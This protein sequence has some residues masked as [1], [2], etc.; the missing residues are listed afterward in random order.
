M[1]DST[2]ALG[3]ALIARGYAIF[4]VR[5]AS[6]AEPGTREYDEAK[7]P[8]AGMLWRTASSRDPGQVARWAQAFPGHRWAIDCGKSGV[9]VADLDEGE[10]HGRQREGRASW[11]A[12]GLDTADAAEVRT[13]GGGSHLFYAEPSGAVVGVNNTGA[14]GRDIDIRGLG[15]YVLAY[16]LP[17]AVD[18]LPALPGVVIERI[19]AGRSQDQSRE[20]AGET[21]AGLD[22]TGDPFSGPSRGFS[23]EEAGRYVGEALDR[24]RAAQPGGRNHA[25][26]A[27]AMQVGHFVP[28]F[29]PEATVVERLTAIAE[30]IGL[31]A[32]EARATIASGLA[33]GMRE[34]YEPRGKSDAP[35]VEG[36]DGA[37]GLDA[38]D[39]LLAEMLDTEGLDEIGDLRPLVKGWLSRNTVA[40]INGKS[41][42]GKSFIALDLAAH[43]GAGIDWRGAKVTQGTVVY[44]IAEGA[45]GF[46]KRVRA[47]E[48]WHGVRMRHVRFLPRPIQ[49]TGS[50]W[51]ILV[52]ACRRIEPALIVLDTQARVTTG[53][54]END[55]TEMG[56]VIEHAERLRRVTGACVTFVHH[57]GHNGEEGRGA[58]AV[59]AGIQTE[60]LVRRG[61]EQNARR[62]EV[63]IPKQKDD[64]DD[65]VL[66]FDMHIMEVG[67]DE[68]GQPV[69]SCVMIEPGAVPH[70]ID[71]FE[72][73]FKDS[74]TDAIARLIWLFQNVWDEGNGA[75]QAQVCGLAREKGMTKATAYRA[76]GAMEGRNMLVRIEGTQRYR[77]VPIEVR[78]SESQDQSRGQNGH[79]LETRETDLET[80]PTQRKRT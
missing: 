39:L 76:W 74:K 54:N 71:P 19:R 66:R 45:E 18:A 58:T 72:D 26:N 68:D 22:G 61:D 6:A 23:R 59:K 4:P 46:R 24:L 12:L 65:A 73:P 25:L 48:K 56:V 32:A 1:D 3:L 2:I 13:P 77:Y 15:G 30:A 10:K 80:V 29:W 7:R 50:E 62:V 34:P 63:S 36:A 11:A 8:A 53:V 79:D 35:S 37:E 14:V 21:G 60:L 38:A 75:T 47:W 43:V 16:G 27:T 31:G 5:P 69:T 57:L 20:T 51:A 78:M 67:K 33:A 28:A 40:R 70:E 64:A 41:T 52:E 17:P 49:I 44:I 55:N 42:H 9:V